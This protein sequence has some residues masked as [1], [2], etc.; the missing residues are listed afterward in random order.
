MINKTQTR[1]DPKEFL[2]SKI[3]WLMF[4]RAV[5]ATI[6]LGATAFIQIKESQLFQQ[7]SPQ[8]LYFLIGFIYVLTI[9]YAF[10]LRHIKR[11]KVF[12]YGQLLGDVLFITILIYLTGGI[13]SI[14]S[15]VYLLPI[16]GASTILYRRGGLFIASASAIFYGALLD[17][18]YYQIIL[19]AGSRLILPHEYKSSYVFYLL[20]MNMLAFY[21]VALLSAYLAEQLRRKEEELK[22]RITDYSQLEK[23]YEHIVQNV[24]SGLI[25]VNEKGLITSFN[26]MAE[27]IT[28]FKLGEVYQKKIADLFPGFIIKE[29]LSSVGLGKEWAKIQQGRWE[30]KF[31]RKDGTILTLGFSVSP[32]KDSN[33]NE[34]G[35]IFIFQDLTK[36]REMEEDL[37]RADRLAAIGTM[38]AGLAHEIR[39]PLASISGS[40]E[41]MKEE[42]DGSGQSPKLMDIVLREIGRL[43]SLI[44]DFLLFAR[45]SSPQ[46]NLVH[47]NKIITDLLQVIKNNP[48]CRPSINFFAKFEEEIY[49]LGD[50]QQLKQAFWNLLINALQAMPNGGEINITL[51]RVYS[52]DQNEPGQVEIII[53]DTGVGIAES[54]LDKIFN[55]FFTTKE[56]GTGLG[57]SIVHRIIE[58][59]GGKI[60][61]QSQLNKGTIFRITLPV[62]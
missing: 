46:K 12:A 55:P 15:W 24:A 26:R 48:E 28:G 58:G 27:E 35:T 31:Q 9:L 7:L 13:E 56:Q 49:L 1:S 47:L 43:D 44:A 2:F 61:V 25:T 5:V 51:R 53:S 10:L 21:L 54:D 39:N 50:E 36:I 14:F 4:F 33:D 30:T 19:P 57:L 62:S 52:T 45:P 18:E 22:E 60:T 32:L 8:F 16:F 59:H 41:I 29:S 23:L 37:K 20:A 34:I 17:L 3:K 38:A 6:L 40:I 42:M 11:L